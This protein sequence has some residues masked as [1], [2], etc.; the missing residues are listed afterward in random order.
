MWLCFENYLLSSAFFALLFRWWPFVKL[1]VNNCPLKFVGLI[2]NLICL[3]WM[4]LFS[5]VLFGTLRLFGITLSLL[6]AFGF[7]FVF[8]LDGVS[9]DEIKVL[10][11]TEWWIFNVDGF[12]LPLTGNVL[13]FERECLFVEEREARNIQ[14]F[15][16]FYKSNHNE[17]VISFLLI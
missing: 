3:F 8:F 12:F 9:D 4:F 14:I 7:W 11:L 6:F 13:L 15:G 2:F 1:S 10:L 17:L 16:W 5:M